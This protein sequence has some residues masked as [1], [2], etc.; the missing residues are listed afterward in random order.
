MV[1]G[2]I[3]QYFSVNGDNVYISGKFF[4]GRKSDDI[5]IGEFNSPQDFFESSY[6]SVGNGNEDTNSIN[7]YGFSEGY[8]IPTT[9]KQDKLMRT[10]F[11]N[12]SQYK[13]Y[14]LLG[15]NCRPQYNVRWR[16]LGL[17]HMI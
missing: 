2:C 4:G 17:K 9:A 14:D 16:L 13:E 6:N 3:W 12:I 1:K 8:I 11:E 7:G 10:T 5:A 15:N